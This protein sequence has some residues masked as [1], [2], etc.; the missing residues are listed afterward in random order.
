MVFLAPFFSLNLGRPTTFVV[1]LATRMGCR[2]SYPLIRKKAASNVA[3]SLTDSIEFFQCLQQ[4]FS[5]LEIS[6]Q[7]KFL[8]NRLPPFLKPPAA[9]ADRAGTVPVSR[10]IT[11]S[12]KK[13]NRP[14]RLNRQTCARRGIWPRGSL[15]DRWPGS[16]PD[17][18]EC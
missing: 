14:T 10:T 16:E 3:A 6:E 15:P 18:P 17:K 9:I 7:I 13:L 5:G 4:K 11:P 2:V 12:L 8:K 1:G